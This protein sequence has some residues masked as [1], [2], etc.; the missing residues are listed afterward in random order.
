M[1]VYQRSNPINMTISHDSRPPHGALLGLRGA[2]CQACGGAHLPPGML[3]LVPE[4]PEDLGKFMENW[5]RTSGF[6][7]Q[8]TDQ[9]KAALYA[10]SHAA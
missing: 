6:S 9:Q 5:L 8:H 7:S 4:L 1:L 10:G 2:M 3:G